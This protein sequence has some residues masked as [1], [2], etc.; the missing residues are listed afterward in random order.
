MASDK[1]LSRV[2]GAIGWMTFNNR[3]RH[4]AVSLDMWAAA[5]VI[6][7]DFAADDAVRVVVLSGA[8]GKSFVSGADISKFEEE[9][10]NA[11]AVAQYNKVTAGVFNQLATLHKPTIAMIGGY[12]LGGGLGVAVACDLRICSDTSQFGLPAARLGLGYSFDGLRRLVAAVGEAFAKEI[13]FTAERF[14][15]SRA[16]AMGLVNQVV[17]ST[18][19]E[20]AVTA[21]AETI[22]A[23]APLTVTAMKRTIGEIA[24]DPDHRDIEMCREVAQACFDSEDYIEGRRAFMEK[25]KPV[26][27]GR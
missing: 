1:M 21:I 8:G 23:N 7:R 9:R 26:F 5:E 6:L 24:K 27:V 25:R 14:D 11:D 3:A 13:V 18:Q 22:A 17:P 19:L 20:A 16:A 2:S 10:S 12:C 4:N 15:A